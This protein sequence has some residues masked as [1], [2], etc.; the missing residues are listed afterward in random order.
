MDNMR[1]T[2]DTGLLVVSFGTSHSKTCRET[3][4]AIEKHL[5]KAMPERRL[6]RGWTSRFIIKKLRERD[7]TAIDTV[8]E[9]LER[10][11]REGIRDLLVVATHLLAGA[12][13]EKMLDSIRSAN[14]FDRI[15]VSRP[16][17]D[18][19]EDMGRLASVI[20]GELMEQAP[21]SS[22]V[23][24]GHGSKDRPEVN[25]VYLRLEKKFREAGHENVFVGTVE[26]EPSIDD[27]LPRL[28]AEKE[29]INGRGEQ[30]SHP[31]ILAPLM[32]VA[33]EHAVKDM[34]GDDPDSWQRR[35]ERELDNDGTGDTVTPVI[36]GLGN[37]QGVQ[38]M[39]EDHAARAEQ[40]DRI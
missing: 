17:L 5:A 7:G 14:G 21:G 3:I 16:L 27:I 20:E 8:E 34:A 22:L 31:V 40:I 10:M 11:S 2:R 30:G 37:Y 28:A 33:G 39:F 15:R 24:M 32:I 23:L 25:E 6:Y 38:E 1:D 12:E 13:Y 35:I 36:R 9:A 29:R 19:D 4:E 26:G 18:G